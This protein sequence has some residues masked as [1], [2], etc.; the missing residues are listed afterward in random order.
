MHDIIVFAQG[1]TDYYSNKW[2]RYFTVEE[3]PKFKHKI[4]ETD[5]KSIP[6]LRI[7]MTFH[8]PDLTHVS[9]LT[10]FHGFNPPLRV[11]HMSKLFIV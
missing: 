4:L 10:Y 6:I 9:R 1:D 5:A 11:P 3:V 8:F 2:E 7:Y